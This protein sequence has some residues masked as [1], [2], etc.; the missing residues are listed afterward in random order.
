MWSQRPQEARDSV[1]SGT[2]HSP[3]SKPSTNPHFLESSFSSL[4]LL[5]LEHGFKM[6]EP[7]RQCWMWEGFFS[8]GQASS[9]LAS[10]GQSPLTTS[11]ADPGTPLPRRP[12]FPWDVSGVGLR[13]VFPVEDLEGRGGKRKAGFESSFPQGCFCQERRSRTTCIYQSHS[14]TSTNSPAV[15]P[16]GTKDSDYVWAAALPKTRIFSP[17]LVRTG[18]NFFF[19]HPPQC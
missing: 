3:H 14:H 12:A 15:K 9:V 8:Q 18:A 7:K 19:P 16:V 10:S 2:G 11:K 1:R 4:E 6:P 5:S 13:I 17:V